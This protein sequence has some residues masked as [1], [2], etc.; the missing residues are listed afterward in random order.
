MP[1]NLLRP[2]QTDPVVSPLASFKNQRGVVL[3]VVLMLMVIIAILGIA[4]MRTGVNNSKVSTGTRI[5]DLTFQAAEAGSRIAYAQAQLVAGW[6]STAAQPT[7]P[8]TTFDTAF[9]VAGNTPCVNTSTSYP[10]CIV[11]SCVT[12]NGTVAS[13]SSSA[14]CAST[15]RLDAASQLQTV[16]EVT[17]I[18]SQN[19]PNSSV[20]IQE[21][22]FQVESIGCMPDPGNTC[23]AMTTQ[24]GVTMPQVSTQNY[25]DTVV[26]ISRPVFGTTN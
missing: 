5:R 1:T 24:N 22:M 12:Q 16:S 15:D 9:Q 3:I 17:Y 10:G 8:T 26:V 14:N 13:Q 20:N 4:A 6:K 11:L 7:A 21:A 18:G 23:V 25:S 19:L 2:I